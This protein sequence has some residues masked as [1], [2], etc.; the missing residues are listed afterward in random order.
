MEST[1]TTHAPPPDWAVRT[2]A[3]RRAIAAGYY[4]DQA[5]A[6]RIIRFAET[7]LIP[8]FTEGEFRLF[9]WQRRFLMSVYGWRR[10]DGS[11]R[12][13]KVLLHVPKKNGKTLLVSII[14]A[15]ELFAAEVPNPLVCSA[16]TTKDNAEQ[17]L[18]HLV[19]S[20]KKNKKLKA[21]AK[22]IAYRK[23]VTVPHRSAEFRA[24]SA[25]APNAEGLNC[26]AVIVDEA[27]GHR[28]PKLFRTLEYAMIGRADGFM[29]IISTAGDDLTH[30]YYAQLVRA[31]NVLAGTDTD[32]TLY[33]EVYE[34]D[35]E[36]D[37]LDNPATWLK[38]NPSL[39]LYPGYTV[40]DFR[41]LWE[42]AKKNTSDKL[43]FERY[44]LNI[45]RRA[46]EAV[47]V[48]LVLW[49]RLARPP[50]D[51]ELRTFPC[52]LGFDGSQT[53]DP[54]SV[55]AVWHLGGKRF[56]VKSWSWVA[57]GGVRAREKTN[58]PKYQ[59]FIAEGC[60]VMSDGDMIDK[61]LARA[62]ILELAGV[63]QVRVLVMD[64]N[65]H[66]VFG[67][68]LEGH[69]FEV[70]RQPQNFKHYNDP[71]KEFAA[72]VAENRILQ[73]GGGWLRWC[74]NSV[75]L[76]TDDYDNVRPVKGKSADHIDG[77]IS[78]LMP[79]ALANA[80]AAEVIQ[81]KSVYESRGVLAV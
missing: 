45:F 37:D 42:A 36:K 78:V 61:S 33:A 63:H 11:R 62:K 35:P 30:F 77:A 76:G 73:D 24:L 9:D 55:G 72:A 67:K 43:S 41:L 75:R 5:A 27:H 22:V 6:D 16:S 50:S 70:Q 28:S 1:D 68:E 54:T 12:F 52:W 17:V 69:G 13:R 4:W 44:R 49:D 21:A 80:A 26:S 29:V 25:D 66:L 2:E 57:A 31:R 65:G 23:R 71:T 46:D 40:E 79:F 14:A 8:K 10:P 7:Y 51:A 74:I 34:C 32:P 18:E 48:D 20:I 53:T 58:L 15:F 38:A 59:Q 64:Q 56:A 19:N 39:G 81:K 60:M 3:D 47:W